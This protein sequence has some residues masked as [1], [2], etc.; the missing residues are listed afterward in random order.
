[1]QTKGFD[2]QVSVDTELPT[3]TAI[4]DGYADLSVDLV[5]TY[6]DSNLI[7]DDP[8]V[9]PIDCAG[10]FGFP[11]SAIRDEA[12]NTFAK[13]RVTTNARYQ[14]GNLDIHLT[15]R[16]IDGTDNAYPIYEDIVGDPR[17]ILA[18]PTIG[19]KSYIDL[20]AG[21]MFNDN[22]SVRLNISNLFDTDPAFMAEQGSQYNTDPGT[23]DLFGR[24]YQLAFSLR[25]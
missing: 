3:W 21:Y 17:S 10:F 6:M 4:F 11:C 1:M 8:N 14:S 20:G 18:I 22:I 13:H 7:Q 16:W 19:S 15:W 5:W 23:Y 12:I 25:Y 2:A 24:S 9:E